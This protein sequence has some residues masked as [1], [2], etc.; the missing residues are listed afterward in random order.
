MKSNSTKFSSSLLKDVQP[1]CR[2]ITLTNPKLRI[3]HLAKYYPPH[4]GGIETHVQTL[5]RAQ[6]RLGSE[7]SVLCVNGSDRNGRS[8]IRTKTVEEM[9]ENVHVTRI[10]RLSSIA[11]FDICPEFLERFFQ[12][13]DESYDIIHLHTPNPTMLVAWLMAWVGTWV[14]GKPQ[15]PLV[16][17]H[18]SDIIKQRILKYSIR[19]LEYLAYK[20][21]RSIVT[22][23]DSYIDG[24][25]FLRSFT[26]VTSL[27]LGLDCSIYKYPSDLAISYAT[28]LKAEHGEIIWLAVGRL[29]YYKAIHVAIRALALVPGKLIIIGVGA[30]E[31]ELKALVKELDLEDRVIWMGRASTEELIGAYH[32]AKAL[33][34]PS[35]ARSE[36]FGL[37]QVE[38]M[39]SGC[40][41]INANIPCSGV[42]WVSRDEK[43]GL[44]VP[45]ND[46]KALAAAA[47][48]ILNEPELR[49]RLVQNSS[50]RLFEF[51]HMT[52]AKRSF[53]IYK[54]SLSN[55]Y[56]E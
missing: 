23:S 22:T 13:A 34:F 6:A 20:Q 55:V 25:K 56:H 3:C 48:R 32:A 30:L 52:M 19:L 8:A 40:P 43:E 42:T 49:D 16:I 41:V 37:V 21:A 38:A 33:W 54:D 28:K 47:Q 1:N 39:A 10:G 51:D 4:P 14:K 27:P 45:L 29:V 46:H 36:G 11:R 17:T 18:H 15:I 12:I 24:S 35:N 7:V 5:A 9:D 26:H 2:T 50:Q 44:T 53:E 31:P